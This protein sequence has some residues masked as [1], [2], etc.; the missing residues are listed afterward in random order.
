[1]VRPLSFCPFVIVLGAKRPRTLVS[2]L[3]GSSLW[4]IVSLSALIGLAMQRSVT[5]LS[6]GCR[7][8][9]VDSDPDGAH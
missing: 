5:G 3:R 8:A 4:G 1:L 7:L 9:A 2:E 6:W